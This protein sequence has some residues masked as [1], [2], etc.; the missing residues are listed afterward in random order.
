MGDRVVNSVGLVR[1][2][3]RGEEVLEGSRVGDEGRAR[4][5][6]ITDAPVTRTA[7]AAAKPCQGDSFEFYLITGSF[8][9]GSSFIRVSLPLAEYLVSLQPRTDEPVTSYMP[10]LQPRTYTVSFQSCHVAASDW[11]AANNVAAT[12]SATWL[13]NT[14]QWSVD[15]GQPSVNGWPTV[16]NRWST[17]GQRPT[18]TGL[19]QTTY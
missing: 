11:P 12:S 3:T 9:D 4:D 18:T 7:S 1:D 17:A 16:V 13:I 5:N 19:P 2:E 15:G 10:N 8:P 6:S 14:G